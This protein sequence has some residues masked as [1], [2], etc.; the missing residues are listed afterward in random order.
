[1]IE[2]QEVMNRTH[3]PTFCSRLTNKGSFSTDMYGCILIYSVSD[4]MFAILF[5][6]KPPADC[7]GPLGEWWRTTGGPRT[8]V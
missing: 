7:H 5:L 6:P 2:G 3:S 1:M 8:I 4:I